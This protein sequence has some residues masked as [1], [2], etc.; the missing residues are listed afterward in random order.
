[1]LSTRNISRKFKSNFQFLEKYVFG[2][3]KTVSYSIEN[4]YTFLAY[5]IAGGDPRKFSQ[6]Y[7]R[8]SL[9]YKIYLIIKIYK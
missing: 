2:M 6:T 1:M 8:D 4:V 3:S 9:A 7:L 5:I